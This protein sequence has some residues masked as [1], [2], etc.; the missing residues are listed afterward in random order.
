MAF[1]F[2]LPGYHPELSRR[3]R[4]RELLKKK[5]CYFDEILG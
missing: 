2:E 4:K 3:N 1:G 5:T